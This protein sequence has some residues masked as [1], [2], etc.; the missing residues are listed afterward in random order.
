MLGLK[1]GKLYPMTV[2]LLNSKNCTDLVRGLN[3]MILFNEADNSDVRGM[4]NLIVDENAPVVCTSDGCF[5]IHNIVLEITDDEGLLLACSYD[6]IQSL[7]D[8]WS[9]VPSSINC[10]KFV[11][12]GSLWDN[13]CFFL[14]NKKILYT[15]GVLLILGIVISEIVNH[16]I[17]W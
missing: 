1:H 4:I 3:R 13:Q 16:S 7:F 9:F 14:K 10:V 12:D 5:P 17:L 8:N 11:C 2:R 6:S 15:V